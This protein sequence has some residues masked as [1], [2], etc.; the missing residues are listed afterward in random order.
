MADRKAFP[1]MPTYVDDDLAL[2]A[3]VTVEE[4][5]AIKRLQAHAWK[6]EPPCTLPDDDRKLAAMSGLGA[7]WGEVGDTVREH[8]TP[9][10]DGRLLDA[11]LHLRYQE[12][13]KKHVARSLAGSKGGRP[14]KAGPQASGNQPTKLGETLASLPVSS[15]S[16]LRSTAV[17]TENLEE[18]K[19]PESP[20]FENWREFVDPVR[21][22]VLRDREVSAANPTNPPTPPPCSR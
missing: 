9:C 13:L 10:E 11:G 1:W 6:Q 22:A 12:Q 14:R 4:F 17:R 20:A 8:F 18:S 7:R 2:A 5:G 21:A 15:L 19:Q 16:V 3:A